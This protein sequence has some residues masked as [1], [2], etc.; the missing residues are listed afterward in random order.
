MMLLKEL[1]TILAC[2]PSKRPL[3]N[4]IYN[5]S[6][7]SHLSV[8]NLNELPAPTANGGHGALKSALDADNSNGYHSRFAA[9]VL[10]DEATL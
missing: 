4:S 10:P 5:R 2:G 8:S 9:D 6:N 1:K 7:Q 3:A